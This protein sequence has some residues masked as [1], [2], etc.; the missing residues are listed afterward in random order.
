M[1]F[2]MAVGILALY[3]AVY[4]WLSKQEEKNLAVLLV[5]TAEIDPVSME[6][7]ILVFY[8]ILKKSYPNATWYLVLDDDCSKEH[9]E[10][11]KKAQRRY[12]YEIYQD[13]QNDEIF[14]KIYLFGN[15]QQGF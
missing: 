7:G 12:H 2:I 8:K 10:I 6:D 11:A 1:V 9:W 3:V 14:K 13:G 4:F 5:I 15:L